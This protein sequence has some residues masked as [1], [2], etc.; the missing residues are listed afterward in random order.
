MDAEGFV[1]AVD[2]GAG[3]GSAPLAGA[4]DYG[5]DGADDLVAQDGG[6][7]H[8]VRAASDETRSGGCSPV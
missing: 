6:C 2:V 4:G 5:E 7:A 1:V 3:R 8:M